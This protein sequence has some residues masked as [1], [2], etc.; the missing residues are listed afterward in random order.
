M[1]SEVSF[2]SRNMGDVDVLM[3]DGLFHL[4]HLVLPN[5]D[6]IAH[7]VSKD[8]LHWK[9]VKNAIF[10]GDPGNWDDDAL[11]TMH[12]SPDPDKPGSWRM[13]YTGLSRAESGRIQR[14]GCALSDDLI[15][16]TKVKEGFPIEASPDFYESTIDEGRS[17]VSFRDPLF[18]HCEEEQQRLLLVSGRVK[19]GPIIRRGCVAK[20]RET[21]RFKFTHEPPLHWPR[22]YDDVEVPSLFRM[23]GKYFLL[24]SVREDIK[25]RYWSSDSIEGPWINDFD[26]V[27]LPGGNYAGRTCYD[28]KAGKRYIFNFFFTGPHPKQSRRNTLPPPKE[29]SLHPDGRLKLKTYSGFDKKVTQTLE[30][31][32]LTPI[33]MVMGNPLAVCDANTTA[34]WFGSDSGFEMFLLHGVYTDFRMRGLLHLDERGKCGLVFR[35]DPE[36]TSGYFVSLDLV[37]GL[38][39]LRAWEYNEGELVEKVFRFQSLQAGYFVSNRKGPWNLELLCYGGYIELSV[40]GY[41]VL[42]L[43]DESFTTGHVGFYVESGRIRVEHLQLQELDRNLESKDP[44]V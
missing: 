7:A 33:G 11:W 23:G 9:R 27:I 6:F 21:E 37:K 43:V 8:G 25:V 13:F 4:F 42:T 20:V 32:Q 26:N 41:I 10:I 18:Y 14:V 44:S 17:W 29:L 19:D 3:H 35:M 22:L 28:P 40:D 39:Q 15:N 38:A 16:W 1:Y 2:E 31:Q 12:V 36:D 30:G 24:G 34:N 5:H